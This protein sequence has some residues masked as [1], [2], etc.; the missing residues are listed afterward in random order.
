MGEWSRRQL[1]R[2]LTAGVSSIGLA[3][4]AGCSQTD[5]LPTIPGTAY[6][7]WLPAPDALAWT[8]SYEVL[9][10]RPYNVVT[11]EHVVDEAVRRQL[12]G[13]AGD[14]MTWLD[15]AADLLSGIY[16]IGYGATVLVTDV[17]KSTL[18]RRLEAAGFAAGGSHE[19]YRLYE[20]GQTAVAV[21]GEAV[22]VAPAA[23]DPSLFLTPVLDANAGT[24]RRYQSG[25][26]D[27]KAL[28]DALGGGD[29]VRW[30]PDANGPLPGVVAAGIAW[31]FTDQLAKTTIALVFDD[32]T[33]V[34][35]ASIETLVG[36]RGAFN[37]ENVSIGQR[38]RTGI[39]TAEVD[40]VT[41]AA[42]S[43]VACIDRPTS[44]TPTAQFDFEFGEPTNGVTITH[45]GGDPVP[46]SRVTIRGTGFR[47][48]PGVDQTTAGT[49]QGD[50]TTADLVTPGDQV[51]VGVAD[52]ATLEVVFE[53]VGAGRAIQL[54]LA[55]SP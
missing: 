3:S 4:L 24:I 51:T 30:C 9:A 27:V 18:E 12:L 42:L 41:T 32:G 44:P 23:S 22:V 50:A 47:D 37:F 13:V 5:P 40:R 11:N 21:D 55:K 53:A 49:W 54:A 38:G 16:Q 1:I 28:V 19:G 6:R 52:A 14:A 29:V 2:G 7:Q 43:A 26:D 20:T 33:D 48:V 34:D 46:R 8:D 15:M 25:D 10:V 39:V 45:S 36:E 17:G 31:R 35:T